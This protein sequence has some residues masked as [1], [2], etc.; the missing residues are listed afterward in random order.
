MSGALLEFDGLSVGLGPGRA[1]RPI[2]DG[3]SL[4]VDAGEIVGVVGES[5]SGKSTMARAALG[6][7]PAGA[8]AHGRIG[9]CGREVLELSSQELRELRS[10]GGIALIHQEPRSAINPVRR[11]GDF[12]TESL[13]LNLGVSRGR[14]VARAERELDAVGLPDAGR[15]LR[16]YAHELSGGMLQR[17]AIAAALTVDPQL[18]IA[19][20]ATSALDVTTQAEVVGL[21]QRLARERGL[22]LLFITHDLALAGSFCDRVAVMYAGRIVEQAPARDL[23]ERPAHPYAE[24]LLACAPSLDG[25]SDMRPIPGRP[26]SLDEEVDGCAF[27]DR[28][29]FAEEACRSWRVEPVE[30]GTSTVLCRRV[31]ELR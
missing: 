19:D 7:F 2:L 14:A 10:H 5:G 11:V 31:E 30:S 26:L 22:G 29:L 8:T 6:V 9:A 24:A 20:E 27:A 4:S 21:L 15:L 17:V 18:L 3:V 16:H 28:C 12:V 1:A 25:S 13:R 23:F